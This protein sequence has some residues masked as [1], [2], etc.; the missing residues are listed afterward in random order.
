VSIPMRAVVNTTKAIN[1][2]RNSGAHRTVIPSCAPA[3]E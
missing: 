2:Q 3:I 1:G